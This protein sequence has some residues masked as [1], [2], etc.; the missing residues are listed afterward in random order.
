MISILNVIVCI[1][2][3]SLITKELVVYYSN[4]LGFIVID[5]VTYMVYIKVIHMHQH[6]IYKFIGLKG[7]SFLLC[8]LN[9]QYLFLW[10]ELSKV[11]GAHNTV[12]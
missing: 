11:S 8:F 3:I 12:K 5:A 4:S 10:L 2:F 7:C 6:G 9:Y 1:C